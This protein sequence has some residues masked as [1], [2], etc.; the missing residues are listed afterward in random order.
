M[1]PGRCIFGAVGLTKFCFFWVLVEKTYVFWAGLGRSVFYAGAG[2][3]GAQTVTR[4]GATLSHATFRVYRTLG[5]LVPDLVF[6]FRFISVSYLSYRNIWFFLFL[7]KQ[8]K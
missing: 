2:F 3:S 6:F 5:E 7:I 1:E 4:G 8:K